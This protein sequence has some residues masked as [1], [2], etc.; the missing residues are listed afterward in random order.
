MAT[1]KRFSKELE[2]N[3]AYTTVVADAAGALSMEQRSFNLQK[4][5][6]SYQ[7]HS[8]HLPVATHQISDPSS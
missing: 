5:S 6:M 3:K 2:K 8:K 4:P 1:R 7:R